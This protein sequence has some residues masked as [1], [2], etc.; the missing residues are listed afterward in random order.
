MVPF[1]FHVVGSDKEL[2]CVRAFRAAVYRRRLGL[3]LSDTLAEAERDR[4]GYVFLLRCNGQPV[5]TARV[6]P[7]S[8]ARTELEQLDALPAWAARDPHCGEVGR[9]ATCRSVGV[10]GAT[11]SSILISACARWTLCHTQIL[12]YVAYNRLVLLPVWRRLGAIDTGERLVIAGRGGTEYA[13]I[14]GDLRD[15]VA[16]TAVVGD[17]VQDEMVTVA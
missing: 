15:V 8:C 3:A 16:R 9:I 13:L 11:T 5:G 7:T 12:R 1:S 17:A 10:T 6:V 2:S 14:T 4:L